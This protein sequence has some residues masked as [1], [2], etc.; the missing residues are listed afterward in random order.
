M[1]ANSYLLAVVFRLLIDVPVIPSSAPKAAL[2]DQG[3]TA[4][5]QVF[6]VFCTMPS[7]PPS[8][9]AEVP[10]LST[11]QHSIKEELTP[12]RKIVGTAGKHTN[13]LPGQLFPST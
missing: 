10:E 11:V 5:L 6:G 9:A 4:E 12:F 8:P 7:H 2:G 1:W 13:S 3:E